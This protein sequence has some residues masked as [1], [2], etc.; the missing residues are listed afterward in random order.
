MQI[1]PNK[2]VTIDY[3]L[4]DDGGQVLESSSGREPLSYVHGNGNIIPGLE[5]ALEGKEP[6]ETVTV[7]VPPEEAYGQ[8]DDNMTAAVPRDRFE[9]VESVEE[10]MQFQAQSD[11]G[12]R[13]VTVVDVQDEEVTVDAN[14]PLA[15]QTLNFEVEIKDVRDAS[16][17]EIEHGHV[18]GE[19]ESDGGAEH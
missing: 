6:G 2:V 14:H 8:R 11:E 9:G 5:S 16:D 12:T 18:H 15:G 13:I 3:T 10:G 17:E 1:A 4:K 7:A 19:G